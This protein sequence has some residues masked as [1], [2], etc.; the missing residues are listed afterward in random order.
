IRD[1]A[2]EV[3]RNV[4]EGA[5]RGP[6]TPLTTGFLFWDMWLGM[7][8]LKPSRS[9][10][11]PARGAA[12]AH[13][14]MAERGEQVIPLAEEVLTVGTKKVSAGTARIRRYV[15]E[16]PVEKQVTLVRERVVVER[17]RPVAGKA[18][19]DTLTEVT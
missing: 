18:N 8:G 1:G 3:S 4:A 16:T 14:Y 13:T 7:A 12:A 9:A 10:P 15:V 19:G 17:R 11:A 6:M 2:R 5:Q